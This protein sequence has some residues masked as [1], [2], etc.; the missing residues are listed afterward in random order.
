MR[1]FRDECPADICFA[2]GTFNSHPYVMAAM[3][4]FLQHLE[5]P[6]GRAV[7]RDLDRI[8][9]ERAQRLN[10]R[11]LFDL[12]MIRQIGF[13]HR[14]P[15]IFRPLAKG[16]FAPANSICFPRNFRGSKRNILHFKIVYQR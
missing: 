2:R 7:Y 3:H 13:C 16:N 1:R 11:T 6:Q 8:W 15:F 9:N 10:Q 5:T 14:T 12:E 4:E